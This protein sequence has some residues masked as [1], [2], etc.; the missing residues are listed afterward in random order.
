[1][2]SWKEF[3]AEQPELA[4]AGAARLPG[5][6]SY[7]ATVDSSGNPRV[8]PVNPILGDGRLFV[9]TEPTSPKAT[10]L[11]QNGRYALHSSVADTHGGGGEFMVRG[12]ARAIDGAAARELAVRAANYVPLDRYVLFELD[13][14]FA[15]Y[16]NY[17]SGLAVR[18]FWRRIS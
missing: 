13:V 1:M 16:T 10:S 5:K 17:P 18:K 3:A 2:A 9:F 6:V 14:E 12:R 8:H 7:L 11:R 4:D 15:V